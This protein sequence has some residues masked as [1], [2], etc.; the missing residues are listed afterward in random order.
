M[1]SIQTDDSGEEAVKATTAKL[2]FILGVQKDAD[3]PKIVGTDVVGPTI[4]S[5]LR[6]YAIL[7]VIL[8]WLGIGIYI[9]RVSEKWASALAWVP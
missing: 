5:E 7:A 3:A 2:E 6:F 8:S 9:W 1:L 4:G